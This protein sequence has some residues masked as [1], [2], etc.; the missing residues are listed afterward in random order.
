MPVEIS[1]AAIIGMLS[2]SGGAFIF[3]GG[4]LVR[5][6]RVLQRLESL[7]AKEAAH[8]DC[9][10][11]RPEVQQRLKASEARLNRLELDRK[12]HGEWLA[13]LKGEMR[14]LIDVISDLK[15]SFRDAVNLLNRRSLNG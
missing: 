13:E 5:L 6:G 12:E 11:C 4:S 7:E 14:T 8:V 10:A 1:A 15:T 9:G 2:L 3:G